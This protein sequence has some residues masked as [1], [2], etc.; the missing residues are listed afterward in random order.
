M[1]DQ[2]TESYYRCLRYMCDSSV[3]N[4]TK[5]FLPLIEGSPFIEAPF[6]KVV[7]DNL[8]LV[9]IGDIPCLLVNIPPGTTKTEMIVKGLIGR[10]LGINPRCRFIHSSANH[11]LALK[12]SAEIKDVMATEDYKAIYP[13]TRIKKGDDSVHRWKTTAGGGV[14]SV[15][16]GGSV[17]GFRAGRM[18]EEGFSGAYI[19]DDPHSPKDVMSEVTR[20]KQNSGVNTTLKTR[21]ALS[22]TPII[23]VMQRLHVDDMSGFVLRGGTGDMWH[24]LLL[25]AII[26]NES[27]YP[28]EYTHGI[29]INHGLPDGLLWEFKYSK[30][31]LEIIGADQH[32]LLAQFMQAPQAYGGDV[33]KD[34]NWKYYKEY[35]PLKSEIFLNDG[36]IVKLRYKNVYCDTAE[37]TG[38]QHDYSVFQLWGMGSDKRIYL[39]DQVRGKWDAPDLNTKFIKFCKKHSYGES[40]SMGIRDR[41]IEDKSSG[42]GLIQWMRKLKGKGY[43][44]D[45]QRDKDKLTRARAGTIPIAE[46][47]VVIP[48]DAYWVDDY[49]REFR[50]FSAFDT[51]ANDDQVDPTMDAIRDMLI[52][53]AIGELYRNLLNRKTKKT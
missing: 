43:I 44:K 46:G 26:D 27:A 10:A 6:H 45:I 22:T 42:T 23:I 3:L 21:K 52:T 47:N 31:E 14:Y 33:F 50:L 41:K 1:S 25:P 51:H 34:A 17:I 35:D 7:S 32:T 53:T 15:A 29:E 4:Y 49:R 13:N 30:I 24:H 18:E 9:V 48:K 19:I 12:N 2:K 40:N 38:Q 20:A 37:K 11:D 16:T 28:I 8:E 5:H 39:L 36:S